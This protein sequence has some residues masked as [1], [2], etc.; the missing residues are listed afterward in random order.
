VDLLSQITGLRLENE[1]LAMVCVQ[2]V[3]SMDRYPTSGLPIQENTQ[4][5]GLRSV[6]REKVFAE[7]SM[8][9]F[10][11]STLS[12][13]QVSVTALSHNLFPDVL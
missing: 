7:E 10:H 9:A 4:L 12:Q 11:Q 13:M 6:L 8:F 3:Y 2:A 1:R 5:E